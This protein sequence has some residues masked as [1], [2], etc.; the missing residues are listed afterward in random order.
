MFAWFTVCL[1]H[2]K[3]IV[4]CR[5]ETLVKLMARLDITMASLL[6]L[7][8][9]GLL[10]VLKNTHW[11]TCQTLVQCWK[12]Q[13]LNSYLA[14]APSQ[15]HQKTTVWKLFLITACGSHTVQWLSG[16]KKLDSSPSMW[17]CHCS[18]LWCNAF[19]DSRITF[20]SLLLSERNC[21]LGRT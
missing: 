18:A 6:L 3:D 12:D 7:L 9:L 19:C 8:L 13:V 20:L 4:Q 2:L 15:L 1:L 16:K 5:R 17:V 21:S 11:A 10:P 14:T